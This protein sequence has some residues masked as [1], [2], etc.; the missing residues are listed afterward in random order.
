MKVYNIGLIGRGKMGKA[1]QGEIEKSNKFNLVKIF[2]KRDIR[3]KKQNIRKFFRSNI[4]DLI[5][6][7]SPVDSHYQYLNYAMKNKK[8]IIVEKPLVENFNELKKLSKLN[9]NFKQKIMIH[10]NDILNFEKFK[11]FKK[12]Y[13]DS[14]KIEMV[15]GKK[16]IK[17]STK[18]PYFDWLP[19]PLA[20]IVKYFGFPKKFKILNYSKI[21]KKSG[22]FEELK[23]EF[24]FKRL[25]IYLM[26]SNFLKNK[27]KKIFIFKNV[28]KE[29]YDGYKKKNQRSIK[30]LLEKFYKKNKINEISLFF[31]SYDLLFRIKKDIE[32]RKIN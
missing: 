2:S 32:R 4:F 12:S 14:K 6:I 20:L 9:R 5:I 27:T 1:F 23:I 28:K 18:K 17:N 10:H 16:D 22:F 19:H 31:K 15:Y 24:S 25:K 29:I 8:H 21:K 30:L 26:F 7:T 3:K 11:I 13:K